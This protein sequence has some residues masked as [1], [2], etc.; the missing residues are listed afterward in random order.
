[1][2]NQTSNKMKNI[3][4]L[5]IPLL[6]ILISGS[7]PAEFNYLPAS[8]DDNQIITYS[9]FT[10]S[11]N[12]E[13]EQADWV[14]YELTDEEVAMKQ[15][16]CDCF[17]S[18]KNVTTKSASKSDYGST[19][20]DLGHL[21]PAADNNLS[22]LANE[23]SFRMSN[24][25]PQLPGFNRGIWKSLEAWTRDKAT[26][27]GSVYVVTGPVFVNNLGVIGKNDVTIPGYYYKILLREE[28]SKM[29]SIAF[30]VPHI[31]LS[32]DIQHYTVTVNTLE[33]ITGI[34]F[35]PELNNSVENRIESHLQP[36]KWGL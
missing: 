5:A 14:A 15:E 1:M 17:K 34:D 12:E 22:E 8:V 26:L 19:G 20:F 21:S 7:N 6:V 4:F 31:G 30:L 27:Y 11:Y 13:H 35:F 28:D 33:T 10:L 18:D 9:Q 29:Y 36:G 3:S 16:R 24:I 32:G 23:E 25:S 2:P